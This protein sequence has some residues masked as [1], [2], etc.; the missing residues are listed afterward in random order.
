MNFENIKDI[1]IIHS[2]VFKKYIK[3]ALV[4]ALYKFVKRGE[5]NVTWSAEKLKKVAYHTCR[6]PHDYDLLL[7]LTK[8]VSLIFSIIPCWYRYTDLDVEH[9]NEQPTLYPYFLYRSFPS[10]GDEEG[11]PILTI[12]KYFENEIIHYE[13]EKERESPKILESYL[14]GK[15]G[16]LFKNKYPNGIDLSKAGNSIFDVAHE[17]DLTLYYDMSN[18]QNI[19]E[20]EH[21]ILV[22]DLYPLFLQSLFSRNDHFCYPKES[23]E[24]TL[25]LDDTFDVITLQHS[26]VWMA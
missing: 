20:Q 5:N 13:I 18:V 21:R 24:I 1:P 8:K 25:L 10:D 22:S 4:N 9:L 3:P 17:D 11:D 6:T 2:N 26:D 19:L 16:S 12:T 15:A 7:Q 23:L 14:I